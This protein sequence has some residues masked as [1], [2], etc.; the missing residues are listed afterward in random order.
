MDGVFDDSRTRCFVRLSG[1]AL[2]VLFSL[3]AA[4]YRWRM[5]GALATAFGAALLLA[6]E[7]MLVTTVIGE[8]LIEH[9]IPDDRFFARALPFLLG[10]LL[11][12]YLHQ[13]E[14]RLR[15]AAVV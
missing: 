15:D 1:L 12:G 5:A 9:D 14:K 6:A 13:N 10:A 11:F 2:F 3:V 4:A 8:T 7:S